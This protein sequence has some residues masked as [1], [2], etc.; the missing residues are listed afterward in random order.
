MA[1]G[2]YTDSKRLE[3]PDPDSFKMIKDIHSEDR[4]GESKI[5]NLFCANC[6]SYLF[7]YQK[8]GPG[9]LL[10]CYKDRI[11]KWG[12][13]EMRTVTKVEKIVCTVCNNDIA[14]LFIYKGFG[15]KR[16]AY[17]LRKEAAYF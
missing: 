13:A 17:G 4:G 3:A 6:D 7:S 8:D 1:A 16:E 11:R 12:S 5:L 14:S 10:R 15:R 9:K 2:I